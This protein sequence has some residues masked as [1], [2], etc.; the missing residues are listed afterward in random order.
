MIIVTLLLIAIALILAT[1]QKRVAWLR[2]L[3]AR[4]LIV[5]VTIVFMLA[6]AEGYLRYFHAESENIIA[7]YASQ[8]WMRRY[9]QTNSLGYRDREWTTDELAGKTSILVLGDSF[10][11]GWG[12][13]DPAD[14]FSDVL[15]AHLGADYAVINAAVFGTGTAEQLDILKTYPLTTPDVVLLQYFLNDI[16]YTGLSLGLLPQPQPIPDWARETYLSNFIYWRLVV[17]N[18]SDAAMFNRS[19]EWSYAAYDNVGIWTPH[20]AE[21]EALIEY[22]EQIN[23]R[24]IVVIFPNMLDPVRSVAYVDRVAQVFEAHG[25]TDVL[26]LYDAAAAWSREDAIVSARDSHPSVAFHH[27]VGDLLYEQFFAGED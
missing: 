8:N 14:R 18:Q 17:G 6:L 23:A 2:A 15:G 27:Y 1:A 5:Y 4:A 3:G 24:L 20:R 16:E 19:W 21:I 13:N 9:W 10:A 22:T 26:K 25:V 11:A 12:I 7:T